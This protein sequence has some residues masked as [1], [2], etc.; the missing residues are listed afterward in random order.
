LPPGFGPFPLERCGAHPARSLP[1]SWHNSN[2]VFMPMRKAEALWLSWN[3]KKAAIMVGAGGINAISGESFISGELK[4]EPQSYC[5]SPQQ[6]WLDGIKSGEGVVRQFVA[7]A[8]GSGASVEAQVCGDDFCGGLQLFVCPPKRTDVCF[9]KHGQSAPC[10]ASGMTAKA[11]KWL[12]RSSRELGLKSG[13]CLE[14]RRLKTVVTTSGG[15]TLADYN[16]QEESTLHLVLRLRGGPPDDEE[17]AL[18]IGGQMRQDVYPD[19]QGPHFWDTRGGQM[20]TVHLASPAMYTAVTGRLPPPTPIS[21]DEYTSSGFPWF[22]LFDED[23]IND[24]EA[25]QVL[26]AVKS[27][28]DMGDADKAE[29]LPHQPALV[30]IVK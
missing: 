9:S 7:T 26:A 21:A 25:P 8:K 1:K 3:G 22:S 30:T 11:S 19:P 28:A 4:A 17:M 13:D 5:V 20:V 2:D 12:Y 16:I 14:M 24:V 10:V 6:P 18:A 15:R 29:R 23:V 27:I